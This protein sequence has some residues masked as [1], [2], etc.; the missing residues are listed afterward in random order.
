MDSEAK[1]K[2]TNETEKPLLYTNYDI[3]M[4][5]VPNEISL[6]F[7]ISGC[8]YHCKGCHSQYLWEYKGTPL[9]L[10]LN[11]VVESYKGMIT[12]VL[13]MGGDQN[14][15]EIEM[16]LKWVKTM[17]LKTCLYSGKDSFEELCS[18]LG[19]YLDYLKVG[20]YDEGLGGLN[21]LTTNQRFYKKTSSLSK[22]WEDITKIFSERKY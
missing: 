22:E 8:P 18:S 7:N 21:S 3:V 14:L 20:H 1:N 5:E 15:S 10:D 19:G 13:F 2:K 6:V 9:S 17:G 16:Q 12:C 4:Q 11:R